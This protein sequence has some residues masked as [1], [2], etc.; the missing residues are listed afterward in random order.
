MQVNILQL[1]DIFLKKL[2]IIF[3]FYSRTEKQQP[4]D[5]FRGLRIFPVSQTPE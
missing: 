5:L 4:D 3:L 2:T 1:Y